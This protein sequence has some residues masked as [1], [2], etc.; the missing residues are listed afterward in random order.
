MNIRTLLAGPGLV[1][2]A[3]AALAQ[4][5]VA[6]HVDQAAVRGQKG[7]RN[8]PNHGDTDPAAR[9][10]VVTQ[11]EGVD[12]LM[13]GAKAA[14]HTECAPLLS[15]LKAR[16]GGFEVCEITLKSRG[17]GKEL[18]IQEAGSTPSGVV[19]IARLQSQGQAHIK[20]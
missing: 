16:G 6:C 1:L 12:L 19:R 20:P 10:T 9:I 3:G 8:V 13:E 5:K 4:D 11:A 7:L 15:A 17:L 18:F 14:K 2:C